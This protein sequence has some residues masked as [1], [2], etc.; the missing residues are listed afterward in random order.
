MVCI[1][2]YLEASIRDLITAI[3]AVLPYIQNYF[4][5]DKEKQDK[6]LLNSCFYLDTLTNLLI[7]M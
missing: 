1:L 7:N 3:P 2:R 5:Q 4:E 6:L